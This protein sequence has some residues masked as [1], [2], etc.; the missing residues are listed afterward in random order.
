MPIKITIFW[1]V[2]STHKSSHSPQILNSLFCDL[3]LIYFFSKFRMFTLCSQFYWIYKK[4]EENFFLNSLH[5]EIGSTVPNN[6]MSLKKTSAQEMRREHKFNQFKFCTNSHLGFYFDFKSNYYCLPP[7]A[8][9][10]DTLAETSTHTND[11]VLRICVRFCFPRSL[12]SCLKVS[13]LI[14]CWGGFILTMYTKRT[15]QK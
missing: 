2:Y 13:F 11:K 8:V 7:R 10:I 4:E 14:Q 15:K 12:G 1:S 5:I 6:K 3:I 9:F